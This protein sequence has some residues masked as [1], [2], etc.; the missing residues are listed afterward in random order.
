M[1]ELFQSQ[2]SDKK[3]VSKGDLSQWRLNKRMEASYIV[4]RVIGMGDSK[5]EV[6]KSTNFFIDV[7]IEIVYASMF[8]G[9][10]WH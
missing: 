5:F 2:I 7:E 6:P 10:I 9:S 4:G 1:N 8:W 3:S